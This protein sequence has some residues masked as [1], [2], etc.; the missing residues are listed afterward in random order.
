M[1]FNSKSVA[2]I[3]FYIIAFIYVREPNYKHI[4]YIMLTIVYIFSGVAVAYAYSNYPIANLITNPL[5]LKGLIL[6]VFIIVFVTL[7]SLIYIIDA[8]YAQASKLKSFDLKLNQHYKNLLTTF[9]NAFLVGNVTFACMLLALASGFKYLTI[10][11][12]GI[13]VPFISV[14]FQLA[15]AI[16]FSKIK[17]D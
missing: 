15:S 16:R 13:L 4:G 9:E 7:F 6:A 2:F 17:N 8:Y 10:I 1:D 11:Y 5:Y 3:Y 14:W 12:I